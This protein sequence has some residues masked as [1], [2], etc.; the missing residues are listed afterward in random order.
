M[1]LT[2]RKFIQRLGYMMA[3]GLIV[4]YVPKIF[5]SI[6]A[7]VSDLDVWKKYLPPPGY[8]ITIGDQTIIGSGTWKFQSADLE[9]AGDSA[10]IRIER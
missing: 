9:Y 6:P 3:G 7:P 5:Y 1:T 10:R 4:P 8:T 2:R